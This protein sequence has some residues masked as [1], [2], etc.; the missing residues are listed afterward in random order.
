MNPAD[1]FAL[2]LAMAQSIV[3]RYRA[4]APEGCD[5]QN[6]YVAIVGTVVSVGVGAYQ[7]SQ[8]SDAAGSAQAGSVPKAAL[9]EPVDFTKMQGDT[10]QGNLDNMGSIRTLNSQTNQIISNQDMQRIMRFV[11]GFKSMMAGE[12]SN[13]GSLIKGNLPYDDVLGIVGNQNEL[14][15]TIGVPGTSAPATLKDLGISRLSAMQTGQ[16]MLSGMIGQAEQVSPEARYSRPQDYYLYPSQ[17]IPWE[18]EQRQLEQQSQQNANNLAAAPNPTALAQ[19]AGA[20]S[21]AS[22]PGN[23]FAGLGPALGQIGGL[24]RQNNSPTDPMNNGFYSTAGG[25]YGAYQSPGYSPVILQNPGGS[26]Y[27]SPYSVPIS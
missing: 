7:A 2:C 15:N 11:P 4:E 26:G 16:G 20:I 10:V 23:S 8:Q 21:G 1:K 6:T 18:I 25:A 22:S 9:Y 17:T 27:Y 3:N 14:G 13:A 19:Q 5:P 24:L 12:A